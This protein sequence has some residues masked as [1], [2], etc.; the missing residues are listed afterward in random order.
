M[1]EYSHYTMFCIV[2]FIPRTSK[3]SFLSLPFSFLLEAD[4]I[5][6]ARRLNF[7]WILHK[8]IH[9]TASSFFK[10]SPS[11]IMSTF[12]ITT[13]NY[14]WS[15]VFLKRIK[16]HTINTQHTIQLNVCLLMNIT[17]GCPWWDFVSNS[18]NERVQIQ[19]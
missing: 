6:W 13:R 12:T 8:S 5:V 9:E 4:K 1:Q 10:Q 14:W 2:F 16:Y 18:A 3:I 19:K 17:V 7:E 11:L 15:M